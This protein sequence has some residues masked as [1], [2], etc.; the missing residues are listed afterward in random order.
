MIARLLLED[1]K[2]LN[3]AGLV[4]E[5]GVSYYT[6]DGVDSRGNKI[7]G[8]VVFRLELSDG[9]TREIPTKIEDGVLKAVANQPR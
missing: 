4:N 1:K 2:F 7:S 3:E 5:G 8:T 9:T 6:K